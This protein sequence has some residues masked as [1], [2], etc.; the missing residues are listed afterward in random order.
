M[1]FHR[2]AGYEEIWK[3][4]DSALLLGGRKRIKKSDVE[5]IIVT[6]PKIKEEW[7]IVK[8]MLT[9]QIRT[10]EF[11]KAEI[12]RNQTEYEGIYIFEL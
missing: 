5:H 1:S 3:F 11:Y 2:E 10:E 4:F 9:E 7:E 6:D 12:L 8:E